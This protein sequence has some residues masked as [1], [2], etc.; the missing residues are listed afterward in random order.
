[1]QEVWLNDSCVTVSGGKESGVA[2]AVRSGG[3]AWE[4]CWQS[5]CPSKVI[6]SSK[7]DFTEEIRSDGTI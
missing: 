7:K 5:C 6:I 1:M 3:G 4:L 2:G